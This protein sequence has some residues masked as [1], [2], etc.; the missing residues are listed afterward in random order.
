[1]CERHDSARVVRLAAEAL[2]QSC[3]CRAE[4]LG[5]NLQLAFGCS[6]DLPDEMRQ[7]LA[8]LGFVDTKGEKQ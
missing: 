7:S 1:M 4:Q 8:L 3:L 5:L 6:T 2:H